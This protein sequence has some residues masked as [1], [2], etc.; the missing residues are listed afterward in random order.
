MD[1]AQRLWDEKGFWRAPGIANL[2]EWRLVPR[3]IVW[4]LAASG[5]I[6][7]LPLAA[8]ALGLIVFPLDFLLKMVG[9]TGAAGLV[10]L[11]LEFAQ[12]SFAPSALPT[13]LP[14]AFTKARKSAI[15]R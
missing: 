8:M 15:E 12:A 6:V 2:Y 11:Y 3:V 4:A 7:A 14:R 1:G 13:W 5:A 9:A 10:G